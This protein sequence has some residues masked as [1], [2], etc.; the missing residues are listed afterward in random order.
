V[1]DLLLNIASQVEMARLALGVG[2]IALAAHPAWS[3]SASESDFKL[4]MRTLVVGSGRETDIPELVLEAYKYDGLFKVIHFLCL[5]RYL[6][7]V[8]V[9]QQTSRNRSLTLQL[10]TPQHRLEIVVGGA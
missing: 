6:L 5:C 1:P 8:Y 7:M 3:W 10:L 2:L 9:E 4:G